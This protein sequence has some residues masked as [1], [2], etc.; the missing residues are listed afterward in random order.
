MYEFQ[1]GEYMISPDKDGY[2]EEVPVLSED[3]L[4]S[5]QLKA[6]DSFWYIYDLGSADSSG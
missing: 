5:S 3:V 2:S 4:L 6:G 1:V